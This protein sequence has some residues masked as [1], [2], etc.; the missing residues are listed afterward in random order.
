MTFV[1]SK[2]RSLLF[3]G[4]TDGSPSFLSDTWEWDGEEWV[5]VADTGP[6]PRVPLLTYDSARN[7]VVLFGGTGPAARQVLSL[8]FDSVRERVVLFGGR[9]TT[10]LE[11]QKDTWEWDGVVWKE[12]QDIGPSPRQGS[13]MVGTGDD[14]L[15]FGGS[16]EAGLL[17]DTWAWDGE[18]WRQRQDI[19]PSPRHSPGMAWDAGRDRVVLFGGVSP[20]P[21]A[22]L[23]VGDTWEAFETP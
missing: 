2:G 8:A 4:Y 3:G 13:G 19:G 1:A 11:L 6:T 23:L 18:H 9:D 5:Q 17:G 12:V 20:N 14:V 16:N 10:N 15:L 7:V 22:S 21:T